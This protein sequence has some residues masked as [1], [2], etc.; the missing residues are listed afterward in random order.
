MKRANDYTLIETSIG[1]DPAIVV[2]DAAIDFLGE[3]LGYT[4]N[5]RVWI[6]CEEVR[7][8]GLPTAEELPRIE[9]AEDQISRALEADGNSIFFARMTAR[10]ERVLIYRAQNAELANAALQRA[11]AEGAQAREWSYQID[12]DPAFGLIEPELSLLA[13]AGRKH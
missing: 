4:W 11:I 8:N 1:G 5:V 6:Q 3:H 13:S 10:G 2:I 9:K 12:A 7:P